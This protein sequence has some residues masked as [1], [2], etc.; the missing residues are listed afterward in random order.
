MKLLRNALAKAGMGLLCLGLLLFL[1][2]GTLHYPNAWLLIAILFV[3]MLV[4]GFV[5]YHRAPA[6]LEKRLH[7]KEENPAQ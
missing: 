7:S 3:P 6:L 5:L 2:A 1:P 4:A